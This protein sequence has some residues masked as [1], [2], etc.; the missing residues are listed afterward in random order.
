[1]HAAIW[2]GSGRLAGWL[3]GW[4][5]LADQPAS[6]AA[7][8]NVLRLSGLLILDLDAACRFIGFV[9]SVG[10]A[11]S[12]KSRPSAPAALAHEASTRAGC[13]GRAWSRA[14]GERPFSASKIV[15]GTSVSAGCGRSPFS[16]PLPLLHSPLLPCPFSPPLPLLH[17]STSPLLHSP[18]SP[19]PRLEG[20]GAP[21]E[22]ILDP[23]QG[24]WYALV[25]PLLEAE[26]GLLP[27]QQL[28]TDNVPY[29]Q[30]DNHKFE[31]EAPGFWTSI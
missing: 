16:P 10:V 8:M 25:A 22:G 3:A 9:F 17:F 30:S 31:H 24:L 5:W 19:A 27:K 1:M 11:G 26:S 23:V 7:A 12:R 15:G 29:P 2:H 21:R 28:G 4:L 20:D 14:F 13:H 18:P 6:W